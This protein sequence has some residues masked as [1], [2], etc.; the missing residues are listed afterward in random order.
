VVY[1]GQA[2]R[3][4]AWIEMGVSLM[5]AFEAL[6]ELSTNL[7]PIVYLVGVIVAI[8]IFILKRANFADYLKRRKWKSYRIDP[9]KNRSSDEMLDAICDA[10]HNG[11]SVMKE[12]D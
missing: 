2:K 8:V 12:A 7:Q 11:A 10:V 5:G 1:Y 4:T 9:Y 6:I 3:D